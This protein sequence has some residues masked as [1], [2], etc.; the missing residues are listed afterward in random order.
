VALPGSGRTADIELGVALND[1]GAQ[2]ARRGL[3]GQ[4]E[5]LLTR[6]ALSAEAL[7]IL[8]EALPAGHP[9]LAVCRGN[10]AEEAVPF[11]PGVR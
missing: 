7:A 2:Y 3:L 5:E 6:A 11:D 9:R 10:A 8:E 1:L 4:A